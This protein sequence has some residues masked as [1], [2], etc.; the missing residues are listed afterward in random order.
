MYLLQNRF[1]T[2]ALYGEDQL[3]Q[4]VAFALHQIIVVSGVEVN[5]PFWMAPYLQILDRHAFG[6]YRDLLFDI[7]LNPG[8]GNYLDVT[9]NTRHPPRMRTTLARSSSCFRSARS[10]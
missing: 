7:T 6:N 10:S 8:M 9:G 2:N 4:R 1:F 5:L 3:R